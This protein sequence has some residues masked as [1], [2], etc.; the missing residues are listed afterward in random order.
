MLPAQ[1]ADAAVAAFVAIAQ[2]RWRKMWRCIHQP[3]VCNRL[4][5]YTEIADMHCARTIDTVQREQ[6]G[7]EAEKSKGVIRAYRCAQL[8]AAVRIQAA[9]NIDGQYGRI[10]AVDLLDQFG[11]FAQ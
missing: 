1:H 8:P 11:I 10:Q 5:S 3:A 7:L 4:R 9:G 6:P 2:A